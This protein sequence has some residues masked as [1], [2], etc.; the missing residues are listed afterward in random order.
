MNLVY[1]SIKW[2][3]MGWILWW[4]KIWDCFVCGCWRI[5]GRR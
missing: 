3:W 5:S 2:I 1:Q 4:R